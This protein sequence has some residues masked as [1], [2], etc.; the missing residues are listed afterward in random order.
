MLKG[1]KTD[2][3][4]YDEEEGHLLMV[5]YERYDVLRYDMTTRKGRPGCVTWFP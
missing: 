5:K 2:A 3:D 4:L 1:D